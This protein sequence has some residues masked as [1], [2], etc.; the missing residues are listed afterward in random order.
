MFSLI[1]RWVGSFSFSHF[2]S[3]H[4]SSILLS[5]ILSSSLSIYSLFSTHHLSVHIGFKSIRNIQGIGIKTLNGDLEKYHS[6]RFVDVSHNRISDLAPI[7]KLPNLVTVNASH[8]SITS[9]SKECDI[10]S[11]KSLNLKENEI[12]SVGDV[13]YSNLSLLNLSHN[14]L[15]SCSSL[16]L[17]ASL[18]SLNISSNEIASFGDIAEIPYG[19]S[20][21]LVSTFLCVCY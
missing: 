6:L 4:T 16:V 3:R 7:H 8:N 9:V 10:P 17:P 5:V 12:S 15:T 13:S 19:L 18:E 14:K 21:N 20:I 1:S 2:L 11:L